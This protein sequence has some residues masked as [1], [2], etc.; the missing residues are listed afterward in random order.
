MLKY[1]K[2]VFFSTSSYEKTSIDRRGHLLLQLESIRIHQVFH[3]HL[4]SQEKKVVNCEIYQKQI[5]TPIQL[6]RHVVFVFK[7][8]KGAWHCEKCPKSVFFSTSSYEKHVKNKH[9]A[10]LSALPIGN[11]IRV[12]QEFHCHLFTSRISEIC[13]RF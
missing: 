12:H 8:T 1:P 2:S 6:K 7:N 13:Q 9:W 5:S 10:R 3:C 11:A 4:L